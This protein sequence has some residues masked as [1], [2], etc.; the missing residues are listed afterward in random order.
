MHHASVMGYSSVSSFSSL[1]SSAPPVSG[2]RQTEAA[3]VPSQTHAPHRTALVVIDA[4]RGNVLVPHVVERG[5]KTS[6]HLLP[7]PLLRHCC[8]IRLP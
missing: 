4:V 7:L 6:A 3:R 8:C 2:G 5:G 1:S